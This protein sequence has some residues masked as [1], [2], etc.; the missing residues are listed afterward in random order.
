MGTGEERKNKAIRVLGEVELPQTEEFLHKYPH[1]LSG[2]EMQ[3]VA[4]ARALVLNPALL[5]VISIAF[6]KGNCIR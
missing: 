4:I 5:I 3:R 2:G 1:H 6:T